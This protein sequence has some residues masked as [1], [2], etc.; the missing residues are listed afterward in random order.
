MIEA[1][2]S[3]DT[4]AD[5]DNDPRR[6]RLRRSHMSIENCIKT[7]KANDLSHCA[8]IWLIHLSSSNGD[9]ENFKKRVQEET[10]IPTYIA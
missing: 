7:L 4:L 5:A 3:A 10:G 6:A 8:E 9:A 1:N 2:Y